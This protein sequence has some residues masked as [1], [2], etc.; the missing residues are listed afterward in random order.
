[1]WV[2]GLFCVL[3]IERETV[4]VCVCVCDKKC[5][6]DGRD[7]AGSVCEGWNTDSSDCA[8]WNTDNRSGQSWPPRTR[9]RNGRVSM[10]YLQQT[11]V[12]T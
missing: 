1:M 6:T 11:T 4:C 3:V 8:G 2:C 5:D 12:T 9:A 10:K 7:C